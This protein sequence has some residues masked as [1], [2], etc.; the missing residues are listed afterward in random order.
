MKKSFFSYAMKRNIRG[1][2]VSENQN[3]DHPRRSVSTKYLYSGGPGKVLAMEAGQ[4]KP[5]SEFA[6]GVWEP[7]SDVSQG[8]MQDM[9]I[10][11][12][13]LVLQL[14]FMIMTN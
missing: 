11:E 1:K 2:E 10:Q 4:S 9:E 5:D 13:R 14:L 12:H 6:S 7:D 8:S 3:P